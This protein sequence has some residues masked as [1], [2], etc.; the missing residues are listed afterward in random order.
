MPPTL[1]LK[2]YSIPF[3]RCPSLGSELWPAPCSQAALEV[4]EGSEPEHRL[5]QTAQSRRAETLRTPHQ[6]KIIPK[7]L[8][9]WQLLPQAAKNKEHN[10]LP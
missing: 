8:L 2:P 10:Q 6:D 3:L 4:P 9:F 7:K 1:A 5:D